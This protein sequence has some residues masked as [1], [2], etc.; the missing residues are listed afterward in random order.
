MVEDGEASTCQATFTM[1]IQIP[2]PK[3]TSNSSSF[4][5]FPYCLPHQSLFDNSLLISVILKS[6]KNRSG[7]NSTYAPIVYLQQLAQMAD[8]EL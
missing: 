1:K 4:H 6:R 8:S 3:L 7:E 2:N 5:Q